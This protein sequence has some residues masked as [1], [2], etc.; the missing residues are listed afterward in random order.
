[1]GFKRTY[2][3]TKSPKYKPIQGY[4]TSE[5]LDRSIDLE[6]PLFK[7]LHFKVVVRVQILFYLL[8]AIMLLSVLFFVA[9]WN[10]T[11][12]ELECAKILSPYCK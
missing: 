11:L 7:I 9:A 5:D 3:L 8:M 2:F 1:M 6:E 10:R 4:D 12:G